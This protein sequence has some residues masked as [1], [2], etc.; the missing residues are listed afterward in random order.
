MQRYLEYLRSKSKDHLL[1][2]GLGDWYDIGTGEPGASKLT[3]AGVT[4][5]AIY[6]QDLTTLAR[7]AVLTGHAGDAVA[8]ASE[9]EAV[10]TAFNR[11]FF[12]GAT[13]LYDRGSQ[14]DQAMPLAVG[15]VSESH[16]AAVLAN[17]VAA[18]RVTQNHVTAGDVG[19]HYLVR[20]LTDNGRS[21]V[22]FDMLSRTD[23]PSYGAQIAAGVTSLAEAWD[24]NPNDSQN[25]FM[26]GHIEERS[27]RD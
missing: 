26:L 17:L 27:C 1:S 25:H 24:A 9:A 7:I 15:L 4:A 6:F 13:N 14:T 18:I 22:R 8:Y 12:D 3:T 10:K 19:F 16:R 11:R 20:A 23:P 2:F 5:S 21:D